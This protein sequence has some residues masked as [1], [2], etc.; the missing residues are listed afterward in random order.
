VDCKYVARIGPVSVHFNESSGYIKKATCLLT[1]S[2]EESC[3]L[4]F[5]TNLKKARFLS[6]G[7][8]HH[9]YVSNHMKSNTDQ[10]ATHNTLKSVPTLPR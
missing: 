9:A 4:E 6:V 3:L 10:H 7:H 1:Y 2:E 5:L 8:R